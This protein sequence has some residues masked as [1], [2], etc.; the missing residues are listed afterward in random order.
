MSTTFGIPAN[1]AAPEIIID[2]LGT[3]AMDLWSLGCTLYEVRLGKRLFDVFQLISLR[4]EDYVNEVA[5]I[6]GKPPEPWARYYTESNMADTVFNSSLVYKE[7][8]S[9]DFRTSRV[10]SLQEKIASC[11]N[12]TGQECAHPR[13]QLISEAEAALLA[14]LL[15]GL[16]RCRPHERLSAQEALKHAWFRSQY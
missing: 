15:E 7:D 6:L 11:H 12:C 16:L 9:C 1:Y 14:E 13:Y 4:K 5:S 8:T 3:V 2:N 10:R